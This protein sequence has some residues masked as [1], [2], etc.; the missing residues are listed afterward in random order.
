M[1]LRQSTRDTEP[2][3]RGRGQLATYGQCE[4]CEQNLTESA[5]VPTLDMRG[6]DIHGHGVARMQELAQ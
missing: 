4:Q 5:G 3:S 6:H 2:R 1:D